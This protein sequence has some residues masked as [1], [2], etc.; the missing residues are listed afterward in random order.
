MLLYQILSCT[1][2]GKKNKKSYKNDKS[3][4]SVS[5]WNEKFE[6]HDG[7]Y[8]ASNIQD[9]F[10]IISRNMI[11]PPIRINLISIENKIT[12]KIKEVITLNF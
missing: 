10:E 8:S 1:I 4:I 5:T 7:S 2:H 11:H 6:L 3:R 9:Y 12:F